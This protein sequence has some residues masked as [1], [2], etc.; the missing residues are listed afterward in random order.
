MRKREVVA[1]RGC[2]CCGTG[3]VIMA[4]LG[5]LSLV[6]MWEIVGVLALAIWPAT[7][8]TGSGL[9]LVAQRKFRRQ[10]RER[11]LTAEVVKPRL[12]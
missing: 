7:L 9:S 1:K 5:P 6:A 8:L 12:Y 3:C 10:P 2:T 4:A 11:E